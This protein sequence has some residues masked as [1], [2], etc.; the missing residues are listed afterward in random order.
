MKVWKL[1]RRRWNIVAMLALHMGNCPGKQKNVILLN[2]NSWSFFDNVAH[3]NGNSFRVK[4]LKP[5]KI[6]E[7][8]NEGL[9]LIKISQLL[10]FIIRVLL[11]N[12]WSNTFFCEAIKYVR[13][14]CNNGSKK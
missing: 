3:N 2:F 10:C 4:R 7:E 9:L 12:Q 6:C 5:S 1:T 11:A 8:V 13:N 14:V